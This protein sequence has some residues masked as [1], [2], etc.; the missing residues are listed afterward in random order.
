VTIDPDILEELEGWADEEED[1]DED[2]EPVPAH[3]RPDGEGSDGGGAL[4]LV[5]TPIGNLGDLSPRAVEALATADVIYCE[6]TRHSRKLLTHAGITGVRLRSL[7]QHNEDDRVEEVVASVAGG[8]TVAVVSDA[9]MPGISDPGSRVVA[10]AVAAGL[11]VSVIP[12]PSAGLAAL[13]TSGLPT[14]RFCF[15]GFLPRSGKERR[16][17]LAALAGETRTTVVFE[18]P[19]RLA[20]TLADLAAT[21]GDDR[22]VAVARE[23]TKLHEEIWRGT[24][25]AA[26]GW[27][28]S[29]PVRGEVVIV[30]AGSPEVEE[31]EVEDGRLLAAL[32]THLAAGERTRGAVDAVAAEFGVARRRVYDLALATRNDTPTGGVE[33]GE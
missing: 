33:L 14:D 10:A 27:A 6:D 11:T 20:A 18:A 24:A 4:V 32:E 21:L 5:A 16:K 19:G 2:A 1:D 26:A 22:R 25:I 31:A 12:G 8:R 17:R 29:G 30:V 3:E 9:G 13:V 15:E 28:A 23:L 7:H